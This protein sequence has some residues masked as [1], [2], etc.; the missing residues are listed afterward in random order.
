[1]HALY[2]S[3]IKVLSEVDLDTRE[4]YFKA[5]DVELVHKTLQDS[6]LKDFGWFSAFQ[7]LRREQLLVY[8]YVHSGL[9]PFDK[10]L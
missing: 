4:S 1:M 2:S 9:V 8:H 5:I 10:I 7:H 6:S 3:A